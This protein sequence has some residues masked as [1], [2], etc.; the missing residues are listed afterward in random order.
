M[1]Q[2]SLLNNGSVLISAIYLLILVSL[3]AQATPMVKRHDTD[4]GYDPCIIDVSPSGE[5]HGHN[6]VQP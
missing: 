6:H 5:Q 3:V 4:N 1:A 2:F